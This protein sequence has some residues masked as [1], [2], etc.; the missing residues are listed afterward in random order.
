MPGSLSGTL[1][2]ALLGDTST[3]Q[4]NGIATEG[5]QVEAIY[6]LDA[7]TRFVRRTQLKR[8]HGVGVSKPVVG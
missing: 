6:R 3:K 8:H 4:V 2:Y 7:P 5:L 1:I